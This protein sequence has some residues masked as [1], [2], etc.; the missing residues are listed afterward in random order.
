MSER[1]LDIMSWTPDIDDGIDE[2]VI[3]IDAG[4]N[5]DIT[6]RTTLFDARFSIQRLTRFR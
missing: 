1:K 4:P 6:M 2:N 5:E 3:S